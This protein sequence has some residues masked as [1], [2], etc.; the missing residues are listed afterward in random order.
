MRALIMLVAALLLCSCVAPHPAA[1]RLQTFNEAD[2]RFSLQDGT[3]TV[4]GEAFLTTRGGEIRPGAGRV[5]QLIPV[6]PYTTEVFERQFINRERLTPRVEKRL[7][8]YVRVLNADSRGEFRFEHVPAG[9]YYLLC[10][11]L[12]EV[13]YEE[14]RVAALGRVTVGEGEQKRVVVTR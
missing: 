10:L 1:P 3:A 12:W 14:T 9:S 6:T 7:D 5:V 2:Y 8:R 13:D 11:I 4:S